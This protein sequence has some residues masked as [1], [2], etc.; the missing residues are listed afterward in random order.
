[1]L[2]AACGGRRTLPSAR[3]AA[4]TVFQRLIGLRQRDFQELIE[5]PTVQ[6]LSNSHVPWP[7]LQQLTNLFEAYLLVIRAVF[8]RIALRFC[9]KSSSE[10]T[11]RVI[12]RKMAQQFDACHLLGALACLRRPWSP[13]KQHCPAALS[14]IWTCSEAQ[15]FRS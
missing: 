9:T 2:L 8:T 15:D 4:W 6:M 7:T 1:M 13:C 11:L 5:M 14:W 3:R 10:W 12:A